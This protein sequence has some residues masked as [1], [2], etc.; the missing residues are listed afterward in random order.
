MVKGPFQL[1]FMFTYSIT[2]I[3]VRHMWLQKYDVFNKP[4]VGG[5]NVTDTIDVRIINFKK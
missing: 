1:A 5:P 4:Q 2:Y 3:E